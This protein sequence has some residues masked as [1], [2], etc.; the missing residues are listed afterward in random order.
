MIK[1]FMALFFLCSPAWAGLEIDRPWGVL[2]DFSICLPKYSEPKEFAEGGDWTP[3]AGD[4]QIQ[5]DGG[6][7][8]NIGSLPTHTEAG[9]WD[10]NLTA[11]EMEGDD[12]V[13]YY[14]DAAIMDQWVTIDTAGSRPPVATGTTDAAGS[15]STT[16]LQP[17]PSGRTKKK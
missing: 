11:T 14:T 5:Q 9:C 4:V 8:I 6:A 3:V 12:V 15:T 17:R 13:I 1:R 16:K 7:F 10:Q 2:T